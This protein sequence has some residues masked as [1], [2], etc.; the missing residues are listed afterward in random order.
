[1]SESAKRRC[2][3]QIWID[4]QRKRGAKLPVD[5]VESM[6]KSGMTQMEIAKHFGVSQKVVWRFMRN[7]GIKARVAAKRDQAGEKN[8]SWKGG[9]VRDSAGYILVKRDGHPRAKA[10]GGYVREHILVAEKILGRRIKRDEHVHHINGDKSD[11]RPENLAVMSASDHISYHK[12][13]GRKKL[14]MA[15]TKVRFPET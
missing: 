5:E 11:N 10:C 1:M 4:A 14:P 9:V 15:V 3:T 13:K 7:N 6:Y 8:S 2:K 12:K